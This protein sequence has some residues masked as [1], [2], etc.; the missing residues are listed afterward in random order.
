[1]NDSTTS[2][3]LL[4]RLQK[5][6]EPA[7]WER[8]VELYTPMIRAWIRRQGLRDSD[9]DDLTQDV[10]TL[11]VQKLPEFQYS[12]EKSFRAWLKTVAVNKTRDF[13][14]RR[15]TRNEAGGEVAEPEVAPEHLEFIEESEY[16]AQLVARALRIMQ[17]DFRPAT[18]QA[19]WKSLVEERP[20]D[21]V[22]AELNISLNAVYVAKS[23][24]LRR[25]REEL[26]GLL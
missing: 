16:R 6:D 3:S 20:A 18:W 22:A 7:A 15:A 25:L 26:D 14:R 17:S 4:R 19:C 24:V 21:E 12:P 2:V 11:L 8:F 1:M 13:Y 5:P 9:T 10:I 23:R